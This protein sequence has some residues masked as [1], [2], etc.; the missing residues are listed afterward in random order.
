MK[1]L[2]TGGAGFVSR[3]MIPF[4]IESGH[5]VICV[6]RNEAPKVLKSDKIRYIRA[7]TAQPGKWQ[8]EVAK[9]DAVVNLAGKNIFSRWSEKYKQAMYDS[10]IQTT[11]NVVEAIDE[12]A[13]PVLCS[14]SAVGYYGDQ[15]DNVV[16]ESSFPGDDFLA[17]LSMDWENT[18]LGAEKKDARVVLPRFALV[19]AKDGGAL[20]SMLPPFKY[21]LGGPMGSGLQW[22]SWIHVKDLV[23]ATAFVIENE[24]ISGPVNFAAPNP[25]RNSDF[26]KTLAKVLNRPSVFRTPK[27]VLKAAL[28]EL[29][30]TLL[31][32]QR[33]V[34]ARLTEAGFEFLY[35]EIESAL[36][37]ELG[38]LNQYD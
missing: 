13:P 38:E 31:N 10:R 30:G 19:I 5:E 9:A 12:S 28:G 24:G 8:E 2:I 32:S 25:V 1:V 26:S 36:A 27:F 33:A 29:G 23:R 34:P 15:G 35:P 37:E 21:F 11:R 18:A 3:H 20:A 22:M 17:R 4:F 6:D 7:D 16:D 14:T